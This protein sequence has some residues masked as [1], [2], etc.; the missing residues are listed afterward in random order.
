MAHGVVAK[1]PLLAKKG[2]FVTLRKLVPGDMI[3]LRD[4]TGSGGGRDHTKF[5]VIEHD[6]KNK[7]TVLRTLKTA[8]VRHD[9]NMLVC[10]IALEATPERMLARAEDLKRQL[11]EFQDDLQHNDWNNAAYNIGAAWANVHE[12]MDHIHK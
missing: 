9:W 8:T 4:V 1:N 11:I 10:V 3:Y 2:E 5:I 6:A 12:G 7:W